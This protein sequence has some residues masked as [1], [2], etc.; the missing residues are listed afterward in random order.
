MLKIEIEGHNYDEWHPFKNPFSASCTDSM[1]AS[2]MHYHQASNCTLFRPQV[3]P[4]VTWSE[5]KVTRVWNVIVVILWESDTKPTPVWCH[6]Q[7]FSSAKE[8][9]FIPLFTVFNNALPYTLLMY[10]FID[11]QI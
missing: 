11:P 2:L 1:V 9:L 7:I 4:L 3:L 8:H 6:L 10:P 5:K